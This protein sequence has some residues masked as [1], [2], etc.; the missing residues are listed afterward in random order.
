MIYQLITECYY[1][2]Y[3]YPFLRRH[4]K[5]QKRIWKK[6]WKVIRLFYSLDAGINKTIF[7]FYLDSNI[8]EYT[9]LIYQIFSKVSLEK[10]RVLS[11]TLKWNMHILNNKFNYCC[12][13]FMLYWCPHLGCY[14]HKNKKQFNPS[15][16]LPM[17]SFNQKRT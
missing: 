13:C 14:G 10:S 8:S 7:F 2:F 1:L 5:A 12:C 4:K 17:P 16:T 11:S 9:S 6:F 15:H 3:H